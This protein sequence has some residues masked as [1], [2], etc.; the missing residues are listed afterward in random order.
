MELIMLFGVPGRNN[1][2]KKASIFMLFCDVQ[3]SRE[4][5]LTW[6]QFKN[7]II[8]T[9]RLYDAI[10][11]LD[12]VRAPENCCSAT[13]FLNISFRMLKVKNTLK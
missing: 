4:D 3:L 12:R 9:I 5:L 10:V 7:S 6:Q 8:D 2:W 13:I 1:P 11:R